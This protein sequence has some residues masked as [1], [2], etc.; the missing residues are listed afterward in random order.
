MAIHSTAI[1]SPKAQVHKD[2]E[3]GPFCVIGEGV[4]IDEGSSVGANTVIDGNTQIGKNCKISPYVSLGL[5]PQDLSYKGEDTKTIIGNNVILREFCTIHKGTAHG[6]G[7]TSIGDNCYIMNYV[8]VGHDCELSNNV[9]LANS[10]ALAGHVK[11]G[12]HVNLGG[13]FAVHQHAEIGE[14]VMAAGFSGTRNSVPPFVLVEGRPVRVARINSVGLK[15]AGFSI[16]E[17][18]EVEKAY[19]LLKTQDTQTALLEIESKGKEFPSLL[20]IV[21]FYRNSKR[22]IIGFRSLDKES[23]NPNAED[24]M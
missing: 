23:D 6:R 14:F 9:I 2:A 3:I 15:R 24:L 18:R 4:T 12:Q 13:L 21:N 22:G 20:K 5:P 19:R 16:E 8:H 1:I 11:I 7:Q 17:I 10:V